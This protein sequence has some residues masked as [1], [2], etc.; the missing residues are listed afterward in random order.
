MK[1]S[2]IELIRVSTQDQAKQD[3]A[4]IQ[5]QQAANR[6]TATQFGLVISRTILI[7]DVSGAMVLH[8]PE[9]QDLVRTMRGRSIHGVVAKEFSRL[10]RPENFDDFALLQIFA[11]TGTIL[12]LPDGPLDFASKSGRLFGA[13][14]AAIAG[15]ERTEILER[16]WAAKEEKRRAGEHAQS[17]IAL[18]L[19]VGYERQ[20]KRWF[21]NHDAQRVREAFRLFL[22]GET[23]YVDVGRKV[24]IDPINLRIILRNPVYTGWRIYNQRR[25]PSL[26]A[27]RT[28]AGGRQGDRPKIER[29]PEDIIRVKILEPLVSESDF[30]RV[31]QILTLKRQN[32]WRA[33]PDHQR[34]F[35]FSGFLR[36]GECGS[37]MY[38]HA[39]RKRDWYVCK[40]RTWPTRVTREKQGMKACTNPYM[41]RT[42]IESILSELLEQQLTN[43][44]I[45]SAIASLY[46]EQA[47]LQG[48][49]GEI[50]RIQKLQ[51]KLH[52]KQRR[53]LDAYLDNLINRQELDRRRNEIKL[54]EDLNAR[55]LSEITLASDVISPQELARSFEPLH[56]WKFLSRS[57]KRK[58]LQAILPEIH[59]ENYH[60]SK[61]AWLAPVCDRHELTHMDKDSSPLPA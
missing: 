49:K 30:N 11:E 34:R 43:P 23:T 5:A 56:E 45:L 7:A 20:T 33:R 46:V 15:V 24:G 40:N 3:R 36:C 1:K 60:V 14:R 29:A 10:M 50:L 27:F 42:R 55:R 37:L 38:S 4:G 57:D 19:G 16:I 47:G 51:E 52:T 35:I 2:V 12:Y 8:S 26:Q 31:Q 22:A 13:L 54:E 21:F 48:G 18:P 32:H 44:E 17:E 39:N 58:L 9:M 6:R 59:L 28:R 61:L 41:E 25:D 53:L